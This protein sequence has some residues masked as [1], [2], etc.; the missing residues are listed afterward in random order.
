MTT[1]VGAG[2]SGSTGVLRR[3]LVLHGV[4][5]GVGFRRHAAR[6]AREL[7]LSG[8]CRNEASSVVA[9]VEGPSEVVDEFARR[10]TDEAPALAVIR[11]VETTE[12]EPSGEPGF[13]VTATVPR[14]RRVR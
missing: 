10:L 5:Q 14:I 9:E 12:L 4:V 2:P 11:T 13:A 8:W 6:L 3:R 1:G 7:E